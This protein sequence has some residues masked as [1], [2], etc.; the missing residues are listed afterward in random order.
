[1]SSLS[2]GH[3]HAVSFASVITGF[4]LTFVILAPTVMVAVLVWGFSRRSPQ[5]SD[6]AEPSPEEQFVVDAVAVR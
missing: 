4:L 2:T 5:V 6:R 1:L 3:G